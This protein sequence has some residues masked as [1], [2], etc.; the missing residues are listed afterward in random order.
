M[1]EKWMM[2]DETK[3]VVLNYEGVEIKLKMRPISW[4]RKNQILSGALT[5]SQG[6]GMSFNFDRYMKETLCEMIVEAP[7]GKTTQL[8]LSQIKPD[9]G[10]MLEA[11]APKAFAQGKGPSDF[12]ERE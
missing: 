10:Q 1:A 3:E 11:L 9:F 4:S 2:D 12:L 5:I 6:G 7:W 8:F